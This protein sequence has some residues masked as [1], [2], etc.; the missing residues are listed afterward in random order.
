[1]R[2]YRLLAASA[3]TSAFL[4]NAPA[5][6]QATTTTTQVGQTEEQTGDRSLEPVDESASRAGSEVIVTGSRIPRPNLESTAPITSVN[7][8]QL[9]QT[10]NLS[11]GDAL[12]RLPQIGATFSQ[13]NS[14]RFIGT[15]GLS[16]LDLRRLG[17]NRTLVL[18]NGRRHV[19]AQPGV[20]TSV[21]VN[22]IP[23]DLIERVDV[24]TGGASA[25]YGADAVAGTV[26]F[27][28]KRDFE[29]L[30]A[31]VQGGTSER[32]DRGS[33]FASVTA[34]KNLLDNRLNISGNAEYSV[35]EDLY[36][37]DRDDFYGG[38]SGRAQFN[39]I[40]NTIGEPA[41]GNGIPDNVFLRNIRSITISE[42][43]LFTATCPTA[44]AGGE[45]AAAFAA[46]RALACNGLNGQ[47]G[48]PLGTTYVFLPNGQL[49]RNNVTTDLRPF[50]SNNSVGGLGSS[51]RLTG[52]LQPRL[53]RAAFNL[54]T[55]FEVSPAFRPF[56]EAK[57]VRIDAVQQGQ[58]TFGNNTFSINNPYLD[59]AS[60]NLLL[61]VLAPGATTFSAQRFNIDFGGRGEDHRRETYRFVGGVDGTF[62]EDW[63]YEVAFNYGRTDTFYTTQG[64]ILTARFNNS[65]NA[66][67]NAAGQIVCGINAD[68]STAND[69][70]A[71]V[72]VNLFG[73][74]NINP[75]ALSYFGV[76][77]TREQRAQQ[78]NATAYVS[79]DLSQLFELPGGPIAFSFG[80][81]YR[82]E[83]AFS[84]FDEL[85]RSGAT[86]LNAI[87]VFDPPA[88]ET[89]EA[90]GEIR[91]PLLRD[92]PFIRELSLEGA[93]R[94]SDYNLGDVGGV[95][96][97]NAGGTWSPFDGLRIRG[98]YARSV[99]V[100]TQSDLFAAPSQTFLNTLND[101]CAANNINN[102]PGNFRAANCAAAG[103]PRT[104]IVNGVSVPF[105]NI[106]ASGI[107]GLNGSNPNL[108]EERSDSWT[109]G[110]VFQPKALPGFALTVDYYNVTI[111]NVIFS[112]APQTIINQ[113][114]DA[115]GGINN[116]YCAA[117][118][119]R[120]D[121]TFQ[122]QG[123]RV[124]GGTTVNYTVGP[125]D[126]SFLSGPFNFAKQKA[127]GIDANINY[128]HDFGGVRADVNGIVTYVIR[129]DNYTDINRPDFINQ[130][131]LESGDPQWRAS[132]NARLD[133]QNFDFAYNFRYIGR[134]YIG[135]FEDQNSLQGR[136][137]E[138]ADRFEPASYPIITYSDIQ[139]GLK[140]F[141]NKFRF[142]VGV[143]NLFDQ[144]PPFAVTGTDEATALFDNIGRFFYA[145]ARIN[146]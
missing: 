6:A 109:L 13:A 67:R 121:G 34:G 62:N 5:F 56:I 25:I 53:E 40:E 30:T 143:D 10:G 8:A 43:G 38:F 119:R 73:Q 129:R 131:L 61:G 144:L 57:Y 145:G 7:V 116:Q 106:I 91:I 105:T 138:N 11:I 107:R 80:G 15:A 23:T 47:T 110:A 39:A 92:I 124:V 102:G 114:Y 45:S 33:Y 2:L 4:A 71:C 136:P 93:A 19:T 12:T 65:I 50:G 72:P 78:Y 3:L 139:L 35:S 101:P 69:D 76:A 132:L 125:N 20:P 84:A 1:M 28:L 108:N 100:P 127:S 130:Q 22:T 51:L 94:Y 60:R 123:N 70:A 77:S 128:V 46:R 29:G 64:N 133:F 83:T 36:F 141:D 66:V 27:I 120:P 24:Q 142:Y 87:P 79:G 18:V 104:E 140:A 48:S 98:S 89:K 115:P 42:G 96:T 146:F 90:Y 54:L 52:Q 17:T 41:S 37:T 16:L 97:Y 68:A 26:N 112:L 32:G 113:C 55:S 14:T 44:A 74:G 103:V 85:T 82:R 126:N 58:P 49:V 137:P 135:N 122:G 118:F 95:W 86:F 63:R 31:R 99:R 59:T 134:Q 9:T 88:L 111:D 75:A 21:D 81:E 117:V